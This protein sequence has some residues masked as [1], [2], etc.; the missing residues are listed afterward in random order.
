METLDL[1]HCPICNLDLAISEFGTCRARKDGKNLY[2]RVCI[3]RKV[4]ASRIAF[5]EY[6]AN[7]K[8]RLERQ[9][10]L[11]ESITESESVPVI[12]FMKLAPVERVRE[13]IR[14][15]AKTQSEIARDTR[16]GK[17]EICDAIANLLLW[18]KEIKSR[19]VDDVRIYEINEEAKPERKAN[20]IAPSLWTVANQIG[21]VVKGERR[22]RAVA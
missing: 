1:K 12:A 20:V 5:K 18:T 10:E 17:D 11:L 3:N 15:G 21:P 22:V 2:C 19:V 14:K 6:K 8:N 4:A 13:A 7:R 16:L 9:R